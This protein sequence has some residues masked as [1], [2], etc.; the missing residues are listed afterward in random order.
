MLASLEK[1]LLAIS[2]HFYKCVQCSTDVQ[3]RGDLEEQYLSALALALRHIYVCDYIRNLHPKKTAKQM[4][5]SQV[6][7]WDTE[8]DGL[9]L[10]LLGFSPTVL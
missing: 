4:P 10:I 7:F 1:G 3:G 6:I 5:C 2:S 9:R 8:N